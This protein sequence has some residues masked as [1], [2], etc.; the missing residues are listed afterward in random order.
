[1]PYIERDRK[2]IDV[3]LEELVNAVR[4]QSKIDGATNYTLTRLILQMLKP[5][6]GWNYA[7]LMKV[8][9]TLECMKQEIYNRLITPYEKLAEYNNGDLPELEEGLDYEA[10]LARH[11]HTDYNDG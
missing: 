6:D 5:T 3:L 8:V 11:I 1:M 4:N 2:S 10:E 9:G 7:S